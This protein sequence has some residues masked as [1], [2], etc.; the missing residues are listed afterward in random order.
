MFPPLKL[1]TAESI[2]TVLRTMDPFL[3]GSR[4][5]LAARLK[6]PCWKSCLGRPEIADSDHCDQ[7][8]RALED[9]GLGF[10]VSSR[11]LGNASW[12]LGLSA[13]C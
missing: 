11:L 5:V 8:G 3:K 12:W 4:R 10:R 1:S 7:Q 6:I 13:V 2:P 9:K